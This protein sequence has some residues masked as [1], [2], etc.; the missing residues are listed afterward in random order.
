MGD[1]ISASAFTSTT[2]KSRTMNMLN[3]HATATRSRASHTPITSLCNDCGINHQCVWDGVRLPLAQQRGA[4][5][6]RLR[7]LEKGEALRRQG[8]KVERILSLKSGSAKSTMI[9]EDGVETVSAFHFPGDLIGPLDIYGKHHHSSTTL[10]ERSTLCEYPVAEFQGLIE[11]VPAIRFAF[12]RRLLSDAKAAEN[13]HRVV[14]HAAAESRVAYFLRD[15]S[16]RLEALGRR[17]DDFSLPMCRH[18]IS[19][20]L[21]LAPETISRS[22]SHFEEELICEVRSRHVQILDPLRLAKLAATLT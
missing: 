10:L 11:G 22:L 20:F 15:L 16:Q 3:Q 4:R 18:D 2:R 21:G 17:G 14:T 19:S 13:H 8:E 1:P 7:M 9:N 5:F 12:M 6:P